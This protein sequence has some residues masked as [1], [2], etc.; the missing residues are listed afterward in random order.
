MSGEETRKT[1]RQGNPVGNS[2]IAPQPAPLA[3][4]QS[5]P[6]ASRPAGQGSQSTAPEEGRSRPANLSYQLL[7]YNLLLFGCPMNQAEPY[8]RQVAR[9]AS[10]LGCGATLSGAATSCVL[11]CEWLPIDPCRQAFA[12]GV[13]PNLAG[14][15]SARDK[16]NRDN[17]LNAAILLSF[18]HDNQIS[19]EHRGAVPREEKNASST[20]DN[21]FFPC[22]VRLASGACARAC[23][24]HAP[25][26][27]GPGSGP[28]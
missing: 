20:E 4:P 27:R 18:I 24:T 10:T 9:G 13:Q 8:G 5:S 7:N 22:V 23:G 11:Q 12:S 2:D 28:Q 21:A 19:F 14:K 26:Q 17:F 1:H 15:A 6:P 3:L 25:P 16:R